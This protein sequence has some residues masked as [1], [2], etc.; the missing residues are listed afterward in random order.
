MKYP[1]PPYR[2]PEIETEKVKMLFGGFEAEIPKI[3]YPITP[4][5]NLFRS[6]RHDNPIWVPNALTDVVSICARGP[7]L[8]EQS[9]V[10]YMKDFKDGDRY[11]DWFGADWTWV[12][13]ANGPMETPGVCVLDDV[14]EWESKVK[15]PSLDPSIWDGQIE[16]FMKDYDPNKALDIN[17]GHGVTERLVSVLEGYSE[18]MLALA[19][20]PEA[21]VDFFNAYADFEIKFLDY[22]FSKMPI[23][24]ITMHDD[25]GTERDTFFSEKMMEDLVFAPTKR[26]VD[27]VKSRGALFRLHSCGNITRFVPYMIDM[28]V[29]FIQIQRRAVNIP[30]LKEKY[31]GKIGF[32]VSLEGG[33]PD[34]GPLSKEELIKAVRN[35]VDIYG[36]DG[37]FLVQMFGDIKAEASWDEIFEF[38]CYSREYYEK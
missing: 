18:T 20:E 15:F 22:L 34:S 6:A 28:D 17:M 32:N 4:L 5:E 31:C 23:N 14:T 29:D 35:T 30:E 2:S 36:K 3:D 9:G 13:S 24:M 21:V 37:G 19:M 7:L 25:W 26:I 1:R 38:Y 8:G 33:G 16:E 12:E 10:K 27:F 11:Q